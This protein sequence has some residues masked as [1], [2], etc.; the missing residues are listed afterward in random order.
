MLTYL[1]K[2]KIVQLQSEILILKFVST[3]LT[4]ILAAVVEN[5][6]ATSKSTSS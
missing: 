2:V 4:Q 5:I 3:V 1:W 6:E